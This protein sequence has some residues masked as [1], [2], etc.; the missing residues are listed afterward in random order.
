LTKIYRYELQR[1]IISKVFLGLLVIVGVFSWQILS[2]ETVMGIAYTAPFSAWSYGA[3]VATVLPLLLVALLFFVAH[4]F[5]SREARVRVL[6]RATPV[7][8]ARHDAIKCAAIVTAFALLVAAVIGMSLVFYASVFQYWHFGAFLV[9]IV[10]TVTPAMLFVMGVGVVVGQRRSALLFVLMLAVL[11]IGRVSLP[12]SLDLLGGTF[13]RETP[14]TLPAGS[15]GE[16]AFQV[17]VAV[18]LS[19]LGFAVVGLLLVG[20]GLRRWE[21]RTRVG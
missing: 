6:T 16:P 17:P 10:M 7:D 1:L 19:K 20:Y 9:P 8:Q 4:L 2:R 18:L 12:S 15:A 14:L 13:F 3:F 5:S 21:N 11:A